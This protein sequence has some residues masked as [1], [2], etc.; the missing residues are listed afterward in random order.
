[1]K[2]CQQCGAQ[3][4]PDAKFCVNCGALFDQ[5]NDAQN[6]SHSNVS[7]VRPYQ[8]QTQQSAQPQQ[9][10]SFD[11]TARQTNNNSRLFLILGWLSAA[12]SLFFIPII[13]GGIGVALGFASRKHN[14]TQGLILIVASIICG[15]LGVVLG[16]IIGSSTY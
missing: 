15:I 16:A 6:N 13:F 14:E 11:D 4:K 7:N 1:M 12:V 10:Q 8:R 2:Y 3:N 9:I 5:M